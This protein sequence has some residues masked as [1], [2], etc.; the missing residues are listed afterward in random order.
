MSSMHWVNFNWVD[1]T[2][3]AVVIISL[4]IGLIRGFICEIISLIAWI[5]AFFLAFKY[6]GAVATHIHFVNANTAKYIIAFVIIAIVVLILGI[7]VNAIVEHLWHRTGVPIM[8]RSLGLLLGIVRGIVIVA[9]VL[10]LVRN[11]ALN[12]EP[13]IKN[14][15]LVPFFNPIVN[16][17]QKILPHK[18]VNISDWTNDHKNDNKNPTR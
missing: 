6:A 17:F 4:L 13:V 15:Q 1:Y 9:F 7:T 11:S 5:A 8:D 16:W 10:L 14:S 18:L 12:N 3:L 2:I